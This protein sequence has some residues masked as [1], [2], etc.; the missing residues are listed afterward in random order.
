MRKAMKTI[1][2]ICMINN[3]DEK[4]PILNDIYR[5]A[6][7]HAGVCDNPHPEWIEFSDIMAEKLKDY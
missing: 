3:E 5:I 4:N 6:H 2:S 7:A 1:Q